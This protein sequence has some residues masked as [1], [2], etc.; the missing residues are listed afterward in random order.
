MAEEYIV[1]WEYTDFPYIIQELVE[2]EPESFATKGKDEWFDIAR[3][4]SLGDALQEAHRLA[5][6]GT[7]VRVVRAASES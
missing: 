7:P 3:H 5:R 1:E 4:W 2:G 6:Q